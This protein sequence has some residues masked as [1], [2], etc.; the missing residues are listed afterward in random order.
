MSSCSKSSAAVMTSCARLSSSPRRKR[1][2]AAVLEVAPSVL[3]DGSAAG[4]YDDDETKR[5]E[6]RV[7]DKRPGARTRGHKVTLRRVHTEQIKLCSRCS[8][9]SSYRGS[10]WTQYLSHERETTANQLR[11][12]VEGRGGTNLIGY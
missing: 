10:W 3:G 5:D 7:V 11:Q 1:L 6:P 9:R 4:P 8:Q 12:P 2:G